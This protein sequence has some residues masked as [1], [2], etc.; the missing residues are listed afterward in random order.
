[1]QFTLKYRELMMM[2]SFEGPNIHLTQELLV[3]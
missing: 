1:M 3:E 2:Q